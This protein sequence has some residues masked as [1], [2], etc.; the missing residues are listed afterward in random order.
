[1]GKRKAA[2]LHGGNEER[3]RVQREKG[4]SKRR[5][6]ER[7]SRRTAWCVVAR[8]DFLGNPPSFDLPST[9]LLF[10]LSSSPSASSPRPE[11]V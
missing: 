7:E 6:G 5:A 10:F 3:V 1:M 2:F 11:V 8:G 4:E 9:S